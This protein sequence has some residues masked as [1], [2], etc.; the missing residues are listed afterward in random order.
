MLYLIYSLILLFGYIFIYNIFNRYYLEGFQDK[1]K[2]KNNKKHKI[3]KEIQQTI[4]SN[5]NGITNYNTSLE[6]KSDT[7]LEG[8]KPEDVINKLKTKPNK[9]EK[10]TINI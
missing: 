10:E 3:L 6:S 2:N 4:G 1:N 5:K 9:N 7:L 8:E